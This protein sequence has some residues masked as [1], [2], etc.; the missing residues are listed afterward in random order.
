[1]GHGRSRQRRG[2]GCR[3]LVILALALLGSTFAAAAGNTYITDLSPDVEVSEPNC[4]SFT[5][6]VTQAS[7]SSAT[8]ALRVHDVDEED[9]ELDEV[10]VNDSFVGYLSGTDGMWSTTTFNISSEIVYGGENTIEVCI[11]P[12]IQQP[13]E[14]DTEW[15]ATI[16]WGQ[17]LVD[18]GSAED[19]ALTSVSA[20]G[21]WNAIAVSAAVSASRTDTY[22]LEINLL[23]DGGNNKDIAI[24]TVS[25]DGGSSTT[26]INTVALPSEPSGGETFTVE[27]NLFNDTTGILQDRRTTTWSSASQ[28]PTDIQLSSDRV[29][30]NLPPG[31]TVGTLTATDPDSTEHSFTL[32]G[33]DVGS[34]AIVDDELRTAVMFDH[35]EQDEVTVRI[36]AE[37]EDQ[38]AFDK[39]FTLT[40]DD[41]N[42]PPIG[43]ADTGSVV[44]G[45][46]T[47][48]DV[49]ANDTDPDEGDT[50]YV[51]DV[52]EPAHGTATI[53][54]T[55]AIVYTP[56]PDGCGE[57][58]FQYTV[59]DSDGAA[60]QVD[61]VVSIQNRAPVA[62][63]DIAET[64]E[65]TPVRIPVLDNDADVGGGPL[66][67]VDP[68]SPEHGSSVIDGQTLRYTPRA[69]YEG[70]DHFVYTIADA[71]GATA[72]ATVEVEVLHT[73]HPPTA[74]AGVFYRGVTGEPLALD[75]G[76]STDPDIE[77][78]LQFR[79]DLDDDGQFDTDW[80][81]DARTE[82]VYDTPYVGRVV[83][84]VRDLYRGQPTGATDRA[85]AQVRVVQRPPE[86]RGVVFV[87]LDG[88]GQPGAEEPRL[89]KIPLQLDGEATAVTGDDGRASFTDLEGGEHTIAITKDGLALLRLQGFGIELAEPT[90][91]LDVPPGAPTVARFPVRAVVGS[92]TG[93]V[94]V[95]TDGSGEQE[96][97]EPGVPGLTVSLGS[98]LERT[99]DEEGRFLFMNIPA[100]E[101]TLTIEGEQHRREQ[102]VSILRGEGTQETV[103]W[104]SPDAGF[105]E[106][107]V[108]LGESDAEGGE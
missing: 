54:G 94:Y 29:D 107:R 70:P 102:P 30:E 47:T 6:D 58:A 61:V 83:V 38:N 44:E 85:A 77:D 104:P 19:A 24:D 45:A 60:A 52:G 88:D 96:Q 86:L 64:N 89:G 4:T 99:T 51:A 36:E 53:Q 12:G 27:V 49:L 3:R 39:W 35:E 100:G 50:L 91:T 71:C 9:G 97:D 67:L 32:I 37:D 14:D 10:Y 63:A 46:R 84:E 15:V 43:I 59:K 55:E 13:D 108:R 28:P 5:I 98:G 106:V 92:L 23:D 93:R 41:V 11:D 101:Y 76:F 75:A 26:R 69:R 21:E 82:A 22:R 25:L 34:F 42:E 7:G 78:R 79:W 2:G 68:G 40:V 48:I 8:L 105:L 87:D 95:D 18:G 33:G 80:L 20:D 65:D 57:D 31:T 103:I 16:D 66:T 72:T 1:M 81:S 73:N 17:I 62:A 74:H 56:D 90:I